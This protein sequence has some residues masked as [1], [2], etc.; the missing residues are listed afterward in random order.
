MIVKP[1]TRSAVEPEL[2]LFCL[3]VAKV[4]DQMIS[5]ERSG[6]IASGG[7]SGLP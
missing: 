2:R 4:G 7:M 1:S 6:Q 5:K 3:V